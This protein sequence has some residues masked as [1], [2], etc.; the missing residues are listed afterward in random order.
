MW[1]QQQ[2]CRR[3]EFAVKIV[4]YKK[5]FRITLPKDL[6]LDKGWGK[7]TE[8]RFVEDEHGRVYLKPIQR[9]GGQQ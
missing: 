7:G 4:E 9:G 6:V 3:Q 5:Q 1:S 2:P 8:L